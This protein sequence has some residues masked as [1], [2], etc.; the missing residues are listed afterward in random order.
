MNLSMGRVTQNGFWISYKTN[1]YC[2]EIGFYQKLAKELRARLK[3]IGVKT[4]GAYEADSVKNRGSRQNC[5]TISVYSTDE[6]MSK[7]PF[8]DSKLD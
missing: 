6:R 7:I 5:L 3:D 4:K 8:Q 1:C 2:K